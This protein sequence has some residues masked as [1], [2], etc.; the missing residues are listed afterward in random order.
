MRFG[1]A[2]HSAVT[3]QFLFDTRHQILRL[4]SALKA[5]LTTVRSFI[6]STGYL[7]LWSLNFSRKTMN[8]APASMKGMQTSWSCLHML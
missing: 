3:L 6:A 4:I 2:G 8:S 1:G 5:T 7:Q